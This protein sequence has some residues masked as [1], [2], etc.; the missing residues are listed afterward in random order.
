MPELPEVETSKEYLKLFFLNSKI[1]NIKINVPKL[2][3]KINQDI[4]KVFKSTKVLKINRI[5]KYILIN[6]YLRIF[7]IT[8]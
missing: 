2:R 8:K 5:G 6:T 7:L 3:W 1:L 4:K